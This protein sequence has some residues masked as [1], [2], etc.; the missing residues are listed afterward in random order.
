MCPCALESCIIIKK[1]PKTLK[2]SGSPNLTTH[3]GCETDIS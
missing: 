1:K 3:D 2:C